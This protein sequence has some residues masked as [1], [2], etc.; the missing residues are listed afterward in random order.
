M[1]QAFY[2]DE[3][4]MIVKNINIVSPEWMYSYNIEFVGSAPLV[5]FSSPVKI[6]P[7]CCMTQW[8]D[9]GLVT[10]CWRAV[11]RWFRRTIVS[12]LVVPKGT[13][14]Y[15]DWTDVYHCL[16][17]PAALA[18]IQPLQHC[19]CVCVHMCFCMCGW[20]SKHWALW[21]S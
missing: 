6:V 3:N 7:R 15:C 17:S 12:T 1:L 20:S 16:Q 14:P 13:D 8:P 18:S 9:G 2:S 19:M 4:E 10:G 5:N 21:G 11:K